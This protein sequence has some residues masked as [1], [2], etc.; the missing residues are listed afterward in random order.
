MKIYVGQGPDPDELTGRI[1]IRSQTCPEPQHCLVG[2]VVAQ[3]VKHQLKRHGGKD[4]KDKKAKGTRRF[5]VRIRFLSPS[6]DNE[7]G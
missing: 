3:S 5:Q 4:D 7:P 1:K 2:D 6:S